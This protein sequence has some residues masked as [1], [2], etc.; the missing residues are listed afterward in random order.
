MSLVARTGSFRRAAEVAGVS[1][2]VISDQIAA[3]ENYYGVKLFERRRSGAYRSM[4]GGDT[5][6]QPTGFSASFRIWRIGCGRERPGA[7]ARSWWAPTNLG[8]RG[9]NPFGRANLFNH[10]AGYRRLKS[11]ISLRFSLWNFD[12]NF[13]RVART[14]CRRLC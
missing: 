13:H 3:I 12:F 7:T 1:Q 5:S 8:I 9:S 4:L 14:S 2:P 6:A 11:K 10:L